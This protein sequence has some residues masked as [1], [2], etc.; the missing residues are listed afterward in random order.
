MEKI[1]V[2]FEKEGLEIFLKPYQVDI[3][4]YLLAHPEQK[5]L[6]ITNYLSGNIVGDTRSRASIINTLNSLED[7]GLLESY[8]ATGKGGHHG[9]YSINSKLNIKSE[10]DVV[11]WILNR[12]LNRVSETR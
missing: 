11:D 8:Q 6:D 3:I 1:W 5:S 9:V 7:W 2:N 12:I 4:K 10:N